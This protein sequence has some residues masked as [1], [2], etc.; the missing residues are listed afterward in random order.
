ML[1][2]HVIAPVSQTISIGNETH[3]DLVTMSKAALTKEVTCL[4]DSVSQFKQKIKFFLSYV[5]VTDMQ[6]TGP[7]T[8]AESAWSSANAAV[9]SGAPGSHHSR[10]EPA[11]TQWSRRRRHR[12]ISWTSSQQSTMNCRRN[13]CNVV[14]FDDV[15]GS[16][17]GWWWWCFV[18]DFL[19]MSPVET[20]CREAELTADVTVVSKSTSKIRLLLI[21]VVGESHAAELTQCAPL[22]RQSSEANEIYIML[23]WLA[24]EAS[25]ALQARDRRRSKRSTRG[26]LVSSAS[27]A[28][29]STTVPTTCQSPM[30][31]Q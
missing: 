28:T 10:W 26:E 18:W 29:S 3:N 24:A 11:T 23:I 9:L 15:E 27:I 1:L 13:K 16:W 17:G 4:Q 7:A 21:T 30:Q 25:T 2:Y 22:L 19:N 31:I 12:L 8:Q 20:A 6:V 14:G 5:G